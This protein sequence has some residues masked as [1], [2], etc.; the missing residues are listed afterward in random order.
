MEVGVPAA[1]RCS[2]AQPSMSKDTT[3]YQSITRTGALTS[4]QSVSLP[5]LDD[6]ANH[7]DIRQGDTSVCATSSLAEHLVQ[8]DE[9][10]LT[11]SGKIQNI[12]ARTGHRTLSRV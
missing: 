10:P 7:D 9:T 8:L 3:T 1:S 12:S 2:N 6:L 4:A 11:A 5:F